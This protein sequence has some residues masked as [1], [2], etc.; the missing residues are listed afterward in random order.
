MFVRTANKGDG[1]TFSTSAVLAVKVFPRLGHRK[2]E[3]GYAVMKR[4]L[5]IGSLFGL[6]LGGVLTSSIAYGVF[7]DEARTTGQLDAPVMTPD[8]AQGTESVQ[9]EGQPPLRPGSGRVGAPAA[10]ALHQSPPVALDAQADTI[11]TV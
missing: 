1:N 11:P 8:R 5:I 9:F 10:P 2:S 7:T 3:T 6:A 4:Q